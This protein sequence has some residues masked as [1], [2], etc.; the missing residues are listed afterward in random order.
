MQVLLLVF[1]FIQGTF[2]ALGTIV[3]VA[4]AKFGYTND[5]ASLFGAL[6]IVGGI[7]GSACFGIYVENT[8]KYKLA[9]FVI[10]AMSFVFTLGSYFTIPHD[11]VAGV[12]ILCFFQGFAMVSIMAVS[13]DYGVELTYPIG[14]SFSTGVLMSSGQFFGIIITVSSSEL[15]DNKL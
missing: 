12:S 14:E 4:T 2:N 3:G 1:G 6:F 9:V 8:R 5:N 10:C 15:I 13:F 7:I 11:T